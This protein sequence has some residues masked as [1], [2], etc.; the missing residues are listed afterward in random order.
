[1]VFFVASSSVVVEDYNTTMIESLRH[2]RQ[3]VRQLSN[4]L[5]IEIKHSRN[6]SLGGR[7]GCLEREKSKSFKKSRAGA[8]AVLN[9]NYMSSEDDHIFS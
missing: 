7:H 3:E 9:S 5:P 1:M 8:S 6:P 2:S 4:Q